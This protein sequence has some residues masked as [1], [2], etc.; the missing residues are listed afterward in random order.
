M[1]NVPAREEGQNMLTVAWTVCL[2]EP[3]RSGSE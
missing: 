2:S 1:N 3:E